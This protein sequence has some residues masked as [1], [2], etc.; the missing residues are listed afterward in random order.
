[1]LRTSTKGECERMI[2]LS[3]EDLLGVAKVAIMAGYTNKDFTEVIHRFAIPNNYYACFAFAWQTVMY[4][5]DNQDDC[6]DK[7]ED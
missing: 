3:H 6:T 7:T 5:Q 2:E 1:M 4:N